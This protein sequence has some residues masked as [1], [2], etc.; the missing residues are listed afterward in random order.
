MG[1]LLPFSSK[2]RGWG[3][4][5]GNHF[6]ATDARLLLQQLQ[7]QTTQLLAARSILFDPLQTK[8]LF[9]NLDL[10]LR[11]CQLVSISIQPAAHRGKKRLR[12]LRLQLL[13][14]VG[15]GRSISPD[16]S[17]TVLRVAK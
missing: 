6:F 11:V 5:L 2:R 9:E 3:L 8:T 7:L 14:K 13:K 10:Q 12:Y 15:V 17:P 4:A 1:T 16:F